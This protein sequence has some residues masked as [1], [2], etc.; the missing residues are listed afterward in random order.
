M[1]LT[2]QCAAI[3]IAVAAIH[4]SLLGQTL[5]QQTYVIRMENDLADAESDVVHTCLLVYP[6]GKYR[7]ERSIQHDTG[8]PDDQ[9][10][11]GLLSG[12]LMAELKQVLAD[13]GLQSVPRPA[14][15]R[16]VIQDV[17]SL[18]ALIPRQNDLQSIGFWTTKDRKPYQANLKPLQAWW[19]GVMKQKVPLAK[20][21]PVNNCDPPEVVY[22]TGKDGQV[23]F[24][25]E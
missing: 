13:Q 23:T 19:K 7:V 3:V 20:K 12:E 4:T 21:E 18:F 8:R 14:P 10:Y 24:H 6:D 15:K 2:W 16:G 17:D 11:L 25:P 5:V 9:V 22:R 1:K